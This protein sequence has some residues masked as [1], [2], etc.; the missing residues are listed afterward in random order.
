V[1]HEREKKEDGGRSIQKK[2][3]ETKQRP[4][5]YTKKKRPRNHSKKRKG[6]EEAQGDIR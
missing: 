1:A 4:D 2:P 6:E 3:R 5:R